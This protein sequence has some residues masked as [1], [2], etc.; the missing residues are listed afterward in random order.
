M[1][2]RPIYPTVHRMSPLGCL[3]AS[4][5]ATWPKSTTVISTSRPGPAAV[6]ADL[7]E[8]PG[9]IL[10][11]SL[12]PSP[13][14]SHHLPSRQ[15]IGIQ[16]QIPIPKPLCFLMG[17]PPGPLLDILHPPGPLEST[18]QTPDGKILY[19]F[20]LMYLPLTLRYPL[21]AQNT[22]KHSHCSQD[23]IPCPWH[24]LQ[25]LAQIGTSPT[26]HLT[27][28]LVILP[29][30]WGSAT[31]IGLISWNAPHFPHFW[32]FTCVLPPFRTPPVPFHSLLS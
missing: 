4:A 16:P 20:P 18:L 9:S 3:R 31:P 21:L 14:P 26:Y 24:G 29:L 5:D 17:L 11:L 10:D 25:G 12:L 13:P 8:V 19:R 7:W 28:S 2:F 32:A 27:S 23:E 6:F 1:S 15:S 22:S 30:F